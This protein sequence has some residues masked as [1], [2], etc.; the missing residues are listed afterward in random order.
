M[1]QQPD[2]LLE[3][4]IQKFLESETVLIA[5][6]TPNKVVL[7]G[8]IRAALANEQCSEFE[9]LNVRGLFFDCVPLRNAD[10]EKFSDV[11]QS[12]TA[13]AELGGLMDVN[14]LQTD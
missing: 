4:I 1:N 7:E 3:G 8:L 12:L 11:L 14:S 13:L 6:K 9:S 10:V 5:A 2:E